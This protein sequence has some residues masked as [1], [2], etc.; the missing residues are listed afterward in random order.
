MSYISLK[1]YRK[2]VEDCQAGIRL[3]AEFPRVYK[4]LFKAQLA[5]GNV[6]EAKQALDIAVRLDSNDA[7]NVKDKDLVNTVIH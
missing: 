4:R 5:L 7:T 2:A 1:M 3:N 6:N